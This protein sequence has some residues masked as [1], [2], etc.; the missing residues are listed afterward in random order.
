MFPAVSIFPELFE[1]QLI[2]SSVTPILDLEA[3]TGVSVSNVDKVNTWAD[4][5]GNGYNFTQTGTA[6]P[7]LATIGGYPCLQFDGVDD[8]ML[9]QNW[10]TLDN[11]SSFTFFRVSK[12]FGVGAAVMTKAAN[13][14]CDEPGSIGWV[15][16]SFLAYIM[17]GLDNRFTSQPPLPLPATPCIL[18][19][20]FVSRTLAHGYVNGS[21]IGSLNPNGV[22]V[23]NPVTDYSTSEP[24]RIGADGTLGDCDLL[25]AGSLFAIRIYSPAL[26]DMQR[27]A[28]EQELANRYGITL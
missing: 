10:A 7:A 19:H 13:D 15:V 24:V 8:W 6:R 12:Q 4:Q 17:N 14:Q 11:M 25:A 3:D 27:V 2:G 21:S 9:G 18:T 23:G 28:V 5:S 20:E 22:Q 26:S 1:S 16:W